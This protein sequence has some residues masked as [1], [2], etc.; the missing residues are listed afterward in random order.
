MSLSRQKTQI[1]P[2][3][4]GRLEKQIWVEKTLVRALVTCGK[5]PTTVTWTSWSEHLRFISVFLLRSKDQARVQQSAS[6]FRN[7]PLPAGNGANWAL[8]LSVS[9]A[10]RSPL[11]RDAL[12]D[13][14]F[15]YSALPI[16]LVD[17][18]VRHWNCY[19]IANSN[20]LQISISGMLVVE[21]ALTYHSFINTSASGG[22]RRSET[23]SSSVLSTNGF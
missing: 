4:T 22:C 19:T 9:G 8:A 17:K 15:I 5:T 6:K 1:S 14:A 21:T 12:M 20:F 23:I 7:L 16:C 2:R 3:R 10:S 18:W 11:C 13:L